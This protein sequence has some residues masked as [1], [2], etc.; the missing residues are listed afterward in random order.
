MSAVTCGEAAVKLYLGDGRADLVCPRAVDEPGHMAAH[1]V[2]VDGSEH[3]E[4]HG[5]ELTCQCGHKL[6]YVGGTDPWG[7]PFREVEGTPHGD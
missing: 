6:V 2:W 4:H 1:F 7:H 3:V 5:R